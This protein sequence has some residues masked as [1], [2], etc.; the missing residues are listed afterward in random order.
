MTTKHFLR[1][2][3]VFL[4]SLTLAIPAFAQR[5]DSDGDGLPDSVD[6]CPK[7][8][9]PRENG[10]CPLPGGVDGAGTPDRD[11]DGVPDY[12]DP[13]PDEAGSGYTNG[14]PPDAGEPEATEEPGGSGEL[15]W[16]SLQS[17]LVAVPPNSR[18]PVNV[19]EQPTTQSAVIG[20]L[21]PG[22]QFEPLYIDYD[23]S[24][25]A[26]FGGAPA[27]DGETWG[28]VAD[29]VVITNGLCRD[30][31]EVFHGGDDRPVTFD[32]TG[33]DPVV[34]IPD[35]LIDPSENP[36]DGKDRY[37]IFP[38]GLGVGAFG[39]TPQ[40]MMIIKPIDPSAPDADC[41]DMGDGFCILGMLLLPAVG[42]AEGQCSRREFAAALN[43]AFITDG[44]ADEADGGL[45]L[46]LVGGED[47]AGALPKLLEAAVRG[48]LFQGLGSYYESNEGGSF[49]LTGL[50]FSLTGDGS[51][52]PS[53]ELL[54]RRLTTEEL[55]DV[56]NVLPPCSLVAFVPADDGEPLGEGMV[57][58]D[59]SVKLKVVGYGLLLPAVQ[60][61]R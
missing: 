36:D 45:H 10:G 30:L 52:L 37:F 18:A 31:P 17:C 61:V 19:R 40:I 26:W 49:G 34:D 3:F 39:S 58:G 48:R 59:G 20:Q 8:A 14:C 42:D 47:V 57:L 2:A 4:I 29:L 12:V 35:R 21:L 46:V 27:A 9:G 15:I 44:T 1:I 6:K 54:L 38:M 22:A 53:P 43:A 60:R 16:G 56:W 23:T 7:Q 55:K 50:T 24:G 33:D 25:G 41:A 13:C 28:W 11:S 32:T 5:G 51:V